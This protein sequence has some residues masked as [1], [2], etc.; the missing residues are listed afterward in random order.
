MIE[1][2][3]YPILWHILKHYSHHNMREFFIALGY[4]GEVIKRY[5]LD[6]LR[7]S[8]NVSVELAERQTHFHEKER[9]NWLVHLIDTGLATNTGGRL[10]RL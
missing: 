5:F 8:G 9:E 4:R 1:I 10:L 6:Y 2:G 7:L 3:G